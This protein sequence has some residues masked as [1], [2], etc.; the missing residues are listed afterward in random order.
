MLNDTGDATPSGSCSAPRSSRFIKLRIASD[1]T[2]AGTTLS[3]AE[4]GEDLGSRLGLAK[5]VYD[6]HGG[7]PYWSLELSPAVEVEYQ[8]IGLNAPGPFKLLPK[9]D[10]QL[11]LSGGSV[12]A[13]IWEFPIGSKMWIIIDAADLPND[14]IGIEDLRRFSI[15]LIKGRAVSL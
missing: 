3:D 11:H 12:A 13:A 5:V 14:L 15:S 9:A 6:S 1:G 7:R 10:W 4:T 2:P 8:P